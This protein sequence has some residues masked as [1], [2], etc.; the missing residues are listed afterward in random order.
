MLEFRLKKNR[1]LDFRPSRLI[2]WFDATPLI[3]ADPPKDADEDEKDRKKDGPGGSKKGPDKPGVPDQTS[4]SSPQP[5]GGNGNGGPKAAVSPSKLPPLEKE[6][7]PHDLRDIQKKSEK[8]IDPTK[9]QKTVT[10]QA[11]LKQI[12][13]ARA[14]RRDELQ[15]VST[16]G[17]GTFISMRLAPRSRYSGY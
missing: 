14:S 2:E 9:K 3:E 8:I 15:D 13:Q 1:R 5:S 6:K 7:P 11:R 10:P 4:S 17:L 12:V 16:R